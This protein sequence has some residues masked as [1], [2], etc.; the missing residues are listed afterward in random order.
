ME[1][2]DNEISEKLRLWIVC[3]SVIGCIVVSELIKIFLNE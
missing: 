3:V 1:N 2:F